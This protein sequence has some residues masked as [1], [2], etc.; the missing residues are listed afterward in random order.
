MTRAAG[1]LVQSLISRALDED[2]YALL[3]SIDLSSAFDVV[4]VKLLIKRM[5]AIGLPEDLIILVEEWLQTRYYYVS[6]NGKHSSIR[7]VYF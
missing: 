1:L 5:R 3:A 6:V 2:N 4:N 7:N